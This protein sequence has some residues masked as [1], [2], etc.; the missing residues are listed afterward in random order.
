MQF[1]I[2]FEGQIV[3]GLQCLDGTQCKCEGGKITFT[4]C[5]SAAKHLAILNFSAVGRMRPAF[6]GWHHIAMRI[7]G[8]GF[9][10]CPEW[11]AHNEVGEGGQPISFD[12]CFRHRKLFCD[13]ANLLQKLSGFF[14]MRCIVARRRVGWHL[15]QSLQKLN[16]L[17]E[18]SI[19]PL[20]K[21]LVC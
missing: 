10:A 5:C 21:F 19:D 6:S 20:I 15:H 13:V 17:I 3:F 11:S 18:V 16:L 4:D 1:N 2:A 12:L 14:G 7:Q 8:N 9:A